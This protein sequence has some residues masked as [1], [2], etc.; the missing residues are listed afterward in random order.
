MSRLRLAPTSAVLATFGAE[1][2]TPPK[3][4]SNGIASA[5]ALFTFTVV[6][7]VIWFPWGVRALCEAA[8]EQ[9]PKAIARKIGITAMPRVRM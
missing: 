3:N 2:C 1:P 5:E 8:D 7:V 6:L 4:A 9:V